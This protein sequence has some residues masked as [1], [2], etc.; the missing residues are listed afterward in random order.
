MVHHRVSD[1][2]RIHKIKFY[3]IFFVI[4]TFFFSFCHANFN[5]EKPLCSGCNR[6]NLQENDEFLVKEKRPVLAVSSAGHALQVFINDQ[7]SGMTLCSQLL[8]TE[9]FNHVFVRLISLGAL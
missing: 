3:S 8:M 5:R 4:I 9:P 1:L 7:L 6:V 2:I